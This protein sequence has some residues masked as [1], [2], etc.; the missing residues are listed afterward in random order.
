MDTTTSTNSSIFNLSKREIIFERLPDLKGSLDIFNVCVP[1]PID[2]RC[3]LA[4]LVG[5]VSAINHA[6]AL[7]IEPSPRILE[8]QSNLALIAEA[9][10]E[11]Y[12]AISAADDR[13]TQLRGLKAYPAWLSLATTGF[14]EDF[15]CQGAKA[16]QG[17]NLALAWI[18]AKDMAAGFMRQI[19]K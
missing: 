2:R 19:E 17:I 4:V 16:A 6:V 3:E 15:Q 12:A 13:D 1:G 8:I 14:L 9:C 10:E 5:A 7:L 11:H 18:G